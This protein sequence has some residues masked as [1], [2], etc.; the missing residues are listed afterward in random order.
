MEQ[1]N[2]ISSLLSDIAWAYA[3]LLTSPIVVTVGLSTTIPLS[4]IGQL[5]INNQTSPAI[6]W[7]GACVVVLSFVFVNHEEAQDEAAQGQ[8]I[9]DQASSSR[10]PLHRE[11]AWWDHTTRLHCSKFAFAGSLRSGLPTDIYRLDGGVLPLWG[12]AF[13]YE[14][15]DFSSFTADQCYADHASVFYSSLCEQE[16]V[17]MR[18]VVCGWFPYMIDDLRT[19]IYTAGWRFDS[20]IILRSLSGLKKR[21]TCPIRTMHSRK[22]I[23]CKIFAWP[24]R[25]RFTCSAW[26]KG[27]CM[28]AKV[29]DI[30]NRKGKGFNHWQASLY[31]NHHTYSI[32]KKEAHSLTMAAYRRQFD[33][34]R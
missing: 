11:E 21:R 29:S 8:R 30:L 3:V 28:L 2:S 1:V 15:H 23:G 10:E 14:Y 24:K 5:L 12:M 19:P 31:S 26:R 18:W 4:L 32:K 13:S 20:I 16:M 27:V 22:L 33:T 17:N 34:L 7:L 25:F 9:L 6:Y